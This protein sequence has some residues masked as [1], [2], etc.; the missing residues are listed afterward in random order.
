MG[1]G[2][3]PPGG[4][5]ETTNMSPFA[6]RDRVRWSQWRA[7]E[8]TCRAGRWHTCSVPGQARILVMGGGAAQAI[9]WARSFPSGR[10]EAVDPSPMGPS[11][12]Q[13]L[14]TGL[15][16]TNVVGD[17]GDPLS[18]Q[19]DGAYDV[20]S[21]EGVIERMPDPAAALQALSARLTTGGV[22]RVVLPSTR[23]DAHL[24]E[25]RELLDILVGSDTDTAAPSRVAVGEALAHGVDYSGTALLETVD[26]ARDLHGDNP[27]AWMEEYVRC[28]SPAYDLTDAFDLLEA[29]GLRFLGWCRPGDWHARPR[30]ADPKVRERFASLDQRAQWEFADR[31]RRPPYAMWVGRKIDPEAGAPWMEDDEDL[32]C[33]VVV[34][35]D[36]LEALVTRG[37]PSETP[38]KTQEFV[39][40]PVPGGGDQVILETPGQ[41]ELELHV[42]YETLLRNMDGVHSLRAAAQEAASSHGLQ[43]SDV[44]HRVV[45]VVRRLIHPHGALIAGPRRG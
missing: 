26:K 2:H 35:A 19:A 20:I 16:Q 29:G 5:V 21:T 12:I 13:V 7:W 15:G 36:G 42:F 34:P 27:L 18:L 28:A 38:R 8:I 43:L 37:R 32:M 41:F 1:S 45:S 6:K 30:L 11:A 17:R 40:R 25:F 3:K 33:R 10:V 31:L 23:R 44:E 4:A 14:A 22:M 9:G 39:I 24:R